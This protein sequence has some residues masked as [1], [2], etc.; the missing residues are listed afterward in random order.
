MSSYIIST[1][2]IA[3]IYGIAAVSCSLVVTFAGRITLAH[4]AMM[5][6]G[7]YSYAIAIDKGVTPVLALIIAPV[8]A[9]AIGAAVMLIIGRME[10]HVFLLATLA[11]QFVALEVFR[12]W[13]ITGGNSGI[14]GIPLPGDVSR[15][16]FLVLCSVILVAV[17][18]G[19]HLRVRGLN[20]LRLRAL[21]DDPEAAAAFGSPV[22]RDLGF[23]FAISAGVAGLAGALD[24]AHV[25]F[26][27]PG[28]FGLDLSMLIAVMAIVGGANVW[29]VGLASVVLV[30]LPETI[31]Y[32]FDFPSSVTGPAQ[33]LVY[34][35]FLVL[36]MIFRPSGLG[37]ETRLHRRAATTLPDAGASA[38]R[39]VESMAL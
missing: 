25:S 10:Q 2:T 14:A 9:G 20:G 17:M 37:R 29:T 31:Y 5:G 13:G 22:I 7:A 24:A 4:G 16:G 33:D 32:L 8:I 35:A 28:S 30:A 12:R 36:I 18:I 34:G 19:L 39:R 23:A 3:A 21:R 11:L 27:V 1:A 26:I 6:I 15:G 38:E